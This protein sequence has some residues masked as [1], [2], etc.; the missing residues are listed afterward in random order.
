MILL[1]FCGVCSKS[2]VM[3][4]REASSFL[5]LSKSF[6]KMS[7]CRGRIRE[8]NRSLREWKFERSTRISLSGGESS[9]RIIGDVIPRTSS[10]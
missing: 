2:G 7:P 8:S 10:R 5:R 9:S 1:V 6:F 4:L 3:D